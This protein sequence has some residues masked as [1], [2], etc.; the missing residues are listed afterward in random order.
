MRFGNYLTEEIDRAEADEFVSRWKSKLKKYGLTHVEFSTHF[1][2]DR[3]N[4][5]RNKPP[6]EVVELDD[7]MRGFLKSWS[8]FETDVKNVANHTAKKRGIN[9]KAIPDN[10]YEFAVS[11]KS[12]KVNF[13]F[14]LKQDRHTKGTAMIL[15]MTIIRK[16]AFKPTK[17]DH[18]I[19]E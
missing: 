1:F 9:K 10:E 12:T 5:K 15:P 7:I 3:L 13:V 6:I 18:I 8:Q 14:V 11:S 16:K 19:V 4:D 2:M 17:G